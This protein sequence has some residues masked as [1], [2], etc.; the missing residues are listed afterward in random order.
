[1]DA[2]PA[3]TLP[4]NPPS[5]YVR[6]GGNHVSRKT[7]GAGP[8]SLSAGS[9]VTPRPWQ[10]TAPKGMQACKPH[11]CLRTGLTAV[12]QPWNCPPPP[13]GQ[14]SHLFKSQVSM[15][16]SAWPAGTASRPRTVI[17]ADVLCAAA[18]P[19]HPPLGK[20]QC[21]S[22]PSQTWPQPWKPA[23]MS[24]PLTGALLTCAEPMTPGHR[25]GQVIAFRT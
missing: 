5:E 22:R 23:R 2:S 12:G 7:L 24:S 9:P 14:H 21:L 8:A 1:M 18:V 6:A 17:N 16:S 10:P 19:S 20:E 15:K 3:H 4:G 25:T 11:R 13:S